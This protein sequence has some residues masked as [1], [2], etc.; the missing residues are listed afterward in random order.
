M[1]LTG[2]EMSRIDRA[3]NQGAVFD[4]LIWILSTNPADIRNRAEAFQKILEATL[5]G[6]VNPETVRQFVS[7]FLSEYLDDL[8]KYMTITKPLRQLK[9]ADLTRAVIEQFNLQFRQAA[10]DI[11]KRMTAKAFTMQAASKPYI[12]SESM[13]R[14]MMDRRFRM[15][16]IGGNTYS[17]ADLET[18]WKTMQRQ[19]GRHDT[20]AYRMRADDPTGPTKNFPL[21]TYV[22]QKMTTIESEAQRVTAQLAN[23]RGGVYTSII[24]RNGTKDS[25]IYHEG[26]IVFNSEA[27][28]T[29]FIEENPKLAKWARQL[30]TVDQIRADGTHMFKFNCKHTLRPYPIQSFDDD[31]KE[32]ELKESARGPKVPDRVTT[33]ATKKVVER[34]TA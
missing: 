15:A 3:L 29:L 12:I 26:K 13:Q 4:D 16:T 20:V 2:P 9:A 5:T 19:Y 25:C 23:A 11:V 1:S 24:P 28:R 27:A 8:S 6:L 21:R 30:A 17:E 7:Q 31:L 14:A 22:D 33:A 18:L 10:G 32:K 34:A